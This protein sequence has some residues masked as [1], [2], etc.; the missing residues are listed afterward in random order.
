MHDEA[1][2][3]ETTNKL[4][5]IL[6]YNK[7]K[8]GVDTV[9]QKCASY[10]TQRITRRWPLAIFFECLILPELILKLYTIILGL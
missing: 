5:I 9:D 3:D 7:T 1:E 4:Q 8:C 6:D 2:I 10:T